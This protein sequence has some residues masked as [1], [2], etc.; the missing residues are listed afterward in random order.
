MSSPVSTLLGL[1]QHKGYN[2]LWWLFNIPGHSYKW[3]SLQYIWSFL[4]HASSLCIFPSC[5]QTLL[6]TG[7]IQAPGGGLASEPGNHP[8][9]NPPTTTISHTHSPFS[10]STHTCAWVWASWLPVWT[11][12]TPELFCCL[13]QQYLRFFLTF[14]CHTKHT[15]ALMVKHKCTHTYI[16][17]LCIHV[18]NSFTPQ[19]A[20]W[21]CALH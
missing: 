12:G 8:K 14:R 6:L 10:Q 16:N 3:S 11:P 20:T 21:I 17:I 1:K 4:Q 19:M 18:G 9:A 13:I 7:G 15:P 5:M 2:Y